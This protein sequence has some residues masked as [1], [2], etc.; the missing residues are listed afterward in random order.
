MFWWLYA[1]ISCFIFF[2]VVLN[3]LLLP[4]N[5]LSRVVPISVLNYF[6]TLV[7][8]LLSF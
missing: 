4:I 8:V 7:L 6:E 3:K 5:V 1:A 2:S